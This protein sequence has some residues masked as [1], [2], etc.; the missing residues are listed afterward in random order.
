ME[1]MDIPVRGGIGKDTAHQVL[2]PVRRD[3]SHW[4]RSLVSDLS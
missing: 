3:Q 1:I 2:N 4:L